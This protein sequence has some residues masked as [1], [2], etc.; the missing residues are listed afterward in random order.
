MSLFFC[1]WPNRASLLVD[2]CSMAG[3]V[4][5]ASKVADG[6]P[7]KTVRLLP[8]AAFV[9]EVFDDEGEDGEALL[10]VEPLPHVADLLAE[11]EDSSDDVAEA[12]TEPAQPIALV[13]P[14]RCTAEADVDDAGNFVRCELA[15]GHGEK[16]AGGG[17]VWE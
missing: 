10:V 9:A 16:H 12:P 6:V 1:A 17:M 5:I 14:V 4:E 7:P 8:P 2:D 15:P 13:Q 11:L 3:A